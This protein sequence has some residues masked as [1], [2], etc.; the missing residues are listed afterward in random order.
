MAVRR[1][2]AQGTDV[3]YVPLFVKRSGSTDLMGFRVV[4]CTDVQY[5]PPCRQFSSSPYGS[6]SKRGT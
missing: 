1:I 3:H 2:V 4:Q 6:K 5:V